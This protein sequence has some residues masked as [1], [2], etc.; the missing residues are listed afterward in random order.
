MKVWEI[1]E[2]LGLTFT[3]CFIKRTDLTDFDDLLDGL[4]WLTNE[5]QKKEL[6]NNNLNKN[7]DQNEDENYLFD[8]NF[9][10]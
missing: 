5:L 6:F 9:L 1:K 2:L 10:I 7:E 4:N 8:L 3:Y